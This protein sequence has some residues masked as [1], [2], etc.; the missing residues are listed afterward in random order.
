[1]IRRRRTSLQVRIIATIVVA[2]LATA[3]AVVFASL[4]AL[5]DALA[6]KTRTELLEAANMNASIVVDAHS[7]EAVREYLE[8]SHEAAG[9]DLYAPPSPPQASTLLLITAED[10][11]RI[12]SYTDPHRE[13]HPLTTEQIE[14]LSD[15]PY[16]GSNPVYI[17]VPGLGEFDAVAQQVRLSGD[18]NQ[19][20][21]VITGV[22][23]NLH[24][25]AAWSLLWRA[26]AL[27]LAVGIVAAG[28]GAAVVV[29]SL[30]PLRRVVRTA[31]EVSSLPLSSGEVSLPHPLDEVDPRSRS[32][33]DQVAASIGRMV[34]HIEESLAVRTQAE[35]QMRRFV[36]EA[37]H[38]LR[39]PLAGII[40]HAQLALSQKNLPVQAC[41]SLQRVNDES[42][43]LA[44]LV[45]SLLILS[46]ADSGAPLEL[47]LVDVS[48][49]AV[50]VFS[51]ARITFPSHS[52]RLNLPQEPAFAWVDAEA[53]RRIVINL[54]SNAGHHTGEGTEVELQILEKDDVTLLHLRDNGP[55]IPEDSLHTVFDRFTQV[56]RG[57][58]GTRNAASSGLGLAIVRSLTQQMTGT[59]S[60][61]SVP[62]NTCFTV[63]LPNKAH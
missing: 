40:G 33:A 28:I 59:V 61:S 1:M 48:T 42:T 3:V 17:N 14:Y 10:Q 34:T 46:R 19:E 4:P 49:I 24:D 20:V 25:S 22:G 6:A 23:T 8:P 32:E 38:E 50:E 36:A 55:G 13:S 15:L 63:T 51:D 31:D 41:K 30:R 45:D 52:W 62:G 58:G 60:V 47:E 2:V 27:G 44:H 16:L 21:L 37:S 29:R 39:N 57:Q 18:R 43:R 56:A 9:E 7:F 53:L 11:A 5:Q 12:A 26:L 35:R 54:A